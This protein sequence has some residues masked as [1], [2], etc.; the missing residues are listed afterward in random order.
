MNEKKYY[1]PHF[2]PEETES[3]VVAKRLRKKLQQETMRMQLLD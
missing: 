1:K 3:V 2:G